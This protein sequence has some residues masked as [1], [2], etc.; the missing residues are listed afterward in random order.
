MSRTPTSNGDAD[1]D[2]MPH[3]SN[4]KNLLLAKLKAVTT[5]DADRN[6]RILQYHWRFVHVT[7]MICVPLVVKHIYI[8]E[9]LSELL[10]SVT[11]MIIPYITPFKELRL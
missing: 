10:L 7:Y 11:P 6:V 3:P 9:P 1:P 2:V 4:M 8:Y 5:L